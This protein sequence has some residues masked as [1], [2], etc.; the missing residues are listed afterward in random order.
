MNQAVIKPLNRHKYSKINNISWAVGIKFQQTTLCVVAQLLFHK[1]DDIFILPYAPFPKKPG[2]WLT[3]VVLTKFSQ[4][5]DSSVLS[6]D[7][8]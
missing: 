8:R 3:L 2:R 4:R 7:C 5:V 1:T 6:K